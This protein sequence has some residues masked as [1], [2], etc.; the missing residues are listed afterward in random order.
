MALHALAAQPELPIGALVTLA[1]PVDFTHLGSLIDA[2][3]DGRIAP[4]SVLDEAGNVPGSVVRQSFKSRK[5]TGD[6]VNY[7]NLWQNLWSDEYMEG[8]Q[9]IGRWLHDHIPVPGALFRQ[10]VSQWL[11][12]NGFV[13]DRLRLGGRRVTLRDVRTPVLA[14]IATRDDITTAAATAPIVDALPGTD[15]ELM[16]V[17][18]G[19]A[20]LFSGRKAVGKVMP[21]IFDWLSAHSQAVEETYPTLLAAGLDE[22]V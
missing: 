5:P 8:H 19:H 22:P 7:A 12:S 17:D 10:V 6:I 14:V 18:A 11:Q 1:T 20:S 4:E 21:G 13:T 2:L 15:V 3:R 9:A 16:P